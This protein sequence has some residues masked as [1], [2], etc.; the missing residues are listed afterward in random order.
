MEETIKQL[1]EAWEKTTKETWHKVTKYKGFD[2][3]NEDLED[4]I[5]GGSGYGAVL[6]KDDAHFITLAH[7]HMSKILDALEDAE[8][9]AKAGE[10]ILE[11]WMNAGKRPDIHKRAQEKLKKEWPTLADAI[12]NAIKKK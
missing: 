6:R 3:V 1:R 12:I 9:R 2:I 10:E 5:Y 11:A 8:R 7:N 4:V